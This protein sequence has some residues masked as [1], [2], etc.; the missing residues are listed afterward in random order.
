MSVERI[1][2]K[3]AEYLKIP[4]VTEYEDPFI[5][6]LA[7][8]LSNSDYDIEKSDRLLVV[9]KKN[10][11]NPKIITAHIDRLGIIKTKDKFEHSLT[12]LLKK[13]TPDRTFSETFLKT[14]GKSF[15]DESVQAYNPEGEIIGEG[16]VKGYTYSADKTGL[17]FEID[18]RE[19]I[20]ENTPVAYKSVLED[21][22][23][24]LSSQIDNAICVAVASQLIEDG[25]DGKFIFS[26]EEE[27]GRGGEHIVKYLSDN[28][29]TSKEIIT[30]DTTPYA[31]SRAIQEGLVVLRNKDR[32]GVFNKDLVSELKSACEYDG[33]LYEM[34]D[35]VIEKQNEQLPKGSKPI[36]LGGTELGR[37]VKESKGTYNGA[38]V[39]IPTTD[40]HT[41][42]ETT[43]RR[44][45]RNYYEVLTKIL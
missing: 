23:G 42:H 39:Q 6:Y 8:D 3:T 16:A 19:D 13:Y 4:S 33:I 28:N 25:F 44:A 37:I 12:T 18:G 5:N 20:H 38:T 29:I 31:D 11:K 10:S 34:K 1:I 14:Y 43:S 26:T 22:D 21:K 30:L 36:D 35:E 45:L 17:F 15:V 2:G 27:T 9:T 32:Y 41:N 7:D 40:Y 24:N